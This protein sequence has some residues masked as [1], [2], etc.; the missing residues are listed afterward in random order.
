MLNHFLVFT[1]SGTYVLRST[2]SEKWL[3]PSDPVANQS[4]DIALCYGRQ[5][6]TETGGG[7][8]LL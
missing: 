3:D 2:T 1:C 6:N 5:E 4:F 8:V 7:P